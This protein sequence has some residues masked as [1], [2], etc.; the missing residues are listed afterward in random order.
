MPQNK[1]TA[2]KTA[3]KTGNAGYVANITLRLLV[4]CALVAL[5]VAGVNAITKDKIELNGRENTAKALTA[6]YESDGLRFAVVPLGYDILDANGEPI[7]VCEDITPAEALA[8]VT[9]VY[10]IQKDESVFGYAVAVA[11][12]G[13][14]DNVKMLVA[15]NADGSAKAVQ[16]L[17]MSE[18][19]GIG[20]KVTKSDFLEKFKNNTAGFSED[21]AALSDIVIAGATRTSEPVTKAVDTALKQIAALAGEPKPQESAVTEEESK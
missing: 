12:M 3:K 7:G 18:T 15:V 16:I 8:D 1:E 2:E 21:A 14:K 6:I 19:K 4:I 20:D 17:S 9:A 11:P 10:E 5:L 13:F